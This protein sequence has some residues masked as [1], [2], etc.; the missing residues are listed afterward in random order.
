[1]GDWVVGFTAIATSVGAIATGAMAIYTRRLEGSARAEASPTHDL[2]AEP[3]LS[4]RRYGP[5]SSP[6]LARAISWKP[7]RVTTPGSLA[8][9]RVSS[10]TGGVLQTTPSVAEQSLTTASP[11]EPVEVSCPKPSRHPTSRRRSSGGFGAL[12]AKEVCK[13]AASL[14]CSADAETARRSRDDH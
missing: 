4:S 13:Q 6:Q 11:H 10:S 14:T 5:I 2:A 8:M 7:L 3:V 12:D 9:N 1:V